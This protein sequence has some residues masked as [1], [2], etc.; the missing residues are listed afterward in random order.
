MSTLKLM[1]L[2][3]EFSQAVAW[4]KKHDFSSSGKTRFGV[5]AHQV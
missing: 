1:G 5:L 4:V 2:E 3:V